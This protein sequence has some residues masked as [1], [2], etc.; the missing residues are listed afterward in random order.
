LADSRNGDKPVADAAKPTNRRGQDMRAA[1]LLAS[2]TA[3]GALMGTMG[4]SGYQ[5]T[6]SV[7]LLWQF[8]A[9]G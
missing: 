2:I 8:E 1:R 3:F 9:G 5:P 7:E 4:T 6:A